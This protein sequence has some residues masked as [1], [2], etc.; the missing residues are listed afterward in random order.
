[1]LC[2]LIS[3]HTSI[4]RVVR[5]VGLELH[6]RSQM[7]LKDFVRVTLEQIVEGAALAQDTISARGGI[8]NTRDKAHQRGLA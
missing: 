3:I 1:M 6:M 8:V 4:L 7:E 2:S 5:Q